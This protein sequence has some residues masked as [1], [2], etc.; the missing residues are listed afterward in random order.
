MAKG[1]YLE[2]TYRKGKPLAAYLYLPRRDGDTAARSEPF[3]PPSDG[4]VVDFAPDGRAIGIEVLS[5]STL[6]LAALNRA[7]SALHQPAASDRDLRP[8]APAA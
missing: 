5:P 8:L 7:L 1:R 3:A 2:V 4:L 6:T